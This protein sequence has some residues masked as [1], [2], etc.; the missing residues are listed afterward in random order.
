MTP[1]RRAGA[2]RKGRAHS[3]GRSRPHLGGRVKAKPISSF[4]SHECRHLGEGGAGWSPPCEGGAL[5]S[6]VTPSAVAGKLQISR[7]LSSRWKRLFSEQCFPASRLGFRFQSNQWTGGLE[8]FLVSR[9]GHKISQPLPFALPV[10]S[11]PSSS[12]PPT[13]MEA[14]SQTPPQPQDSHLHY[15]GSFRL[16]VVVV[17]C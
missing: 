9:L 17:G 3:T 15:R 13:P 6:E 12:R 2:Q 7:A 14:L 1:S 4:R 8:V 5:T 11:Q 10:D 16:S